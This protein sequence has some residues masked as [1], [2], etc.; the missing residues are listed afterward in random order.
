[1]SKPGL[2]KTTFML[3][4]NLLLHRSTAWGKYSCTCLP[5]TSSLRYK[6]TGGHANISDPPPASSL[7]DPTE[8]RSIS[9]SSD[10]N[11]HQPSSSS[12]SSP[13]ALIDPS[14]VK[15]PPHTTTYQNPPFNTHAFFNELEKTF[16]K[17]TA[18]S[19]MRATRALLVDRIGKVK[20][21][22]LTYKDLDNVCCRVARSARG[23][24]FAFFDLAAPPQQAYLFR[25]ALS[26]MRTEMT[27]RSRA[28]T[29]AI[30][31][32]SASLRREV[33]SLGARLKESVDGLKHECVKGFPFSLFA[34]HLG[35]IQDPNGRRQSKE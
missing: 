2:G 11:D 24:C 32:Q 28:E 14:T 34:A 35:I 13:P 6:H 26:E 17:Q 21:D 20:R 7:G 12:S 25:A 31:A 27:T 1:M 16:P 9:L 3:A 8:S 10:S 4:R 29:A 23:F 33:D 30:R 19:L 22:G 5:T 15:A 18:R